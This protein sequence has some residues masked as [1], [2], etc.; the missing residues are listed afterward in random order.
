M[1]RGNMLRR[2][3]RIAT[4]A[5]DGMRSFTAPGSTHCIGLAVALSLTREFFRMPVALHITE[6][7]PK[8]RHALACRLPAECAFALPLDFL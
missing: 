5:T 7:R 8:N 2:C 1:V 6:G 3:L 4:Q